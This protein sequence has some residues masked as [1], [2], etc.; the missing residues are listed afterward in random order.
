MRT[1]ERT[2]QF[3]RDYK[4]EAKGTHRAY[5]DEALADLVTVLAGMS[6]WRPNT[7]TTRSW[8]NGKT[9]GTAT[10]GQTYC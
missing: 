2:A 7:V 8:G 5:L 4:R 9:S 6:R 3:K 1:I 10:S